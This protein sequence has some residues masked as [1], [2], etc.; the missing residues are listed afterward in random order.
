MKGLSA[1][2]GTPVLNARPADTE[3]RSRGLQR[4][5]GAASSRVH[6]LHLR[7]RARVTFSCAGAA[8]DDELLATVPGYAGANPRHRPGACRPCQYA[9]ARQRSRGLARGPR[10]ACESRIAFAAWG[11]Q[12]QNGLPFAQSMP[13]FR[14]NSGITQTPGD[15][16]GGLHRR[17]RQW[18]RSH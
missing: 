15:G 3:R 1:L 8:M 9:C 16:G 2:R 17:S 14:K 12:R 6:R 5:D 11:S 18:A 10:A 7:Q 4:A 13:S